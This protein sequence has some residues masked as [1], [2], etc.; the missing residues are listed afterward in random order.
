MLQLTV[1]CGKT[2]NCPENS[3]RTGLFYELSGNGCK[4]T[5]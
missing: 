1:F 5:V 4:S 2:G 3:N